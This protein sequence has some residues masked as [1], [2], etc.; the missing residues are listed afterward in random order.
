MKIQ[1]L[2]KIRAIFGRREITPEEEAKYAKINK[3]E[4]IKKLYNEYH[5]TNDDMKNAKEELE[6]NILEKEQ[7][8]SIEKDKGIKEE[9]EI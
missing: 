8:I 4:E 3:I 7:N 1:I 2:K 9:F 6:N 5:I